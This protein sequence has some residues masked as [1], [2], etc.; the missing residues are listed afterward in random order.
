M[1]I[2]REIPTKFKEALLLDIEINSFKF[3]LL[4]IY[5]APRVNKIEFVDTLDDF[6]ESF[7][8]SNDPIVIYG[9]INIDILK[10]NKLTKNYKRSVAS[11]GFAINESIPTSV[12]DKYSTYLDHFIFKNIK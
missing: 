6:L 9:D 11:N 2:L 7:T 1:P 8:K 12:V 4:T 5:V 10:E 3:K